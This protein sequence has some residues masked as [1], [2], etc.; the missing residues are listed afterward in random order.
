M[1]Y[2]YKGEYLKDIPKKY[3]LVPNIQ[4][5]IDDLD[6]KRLNKN[7]RTSLDKA[8][9]GILLKEFMDKKSKDYLLAPFIGDAT[10]VGIYKA[11]TKHNEYYFV[12]LSNERELMCEQELYDLSAVKKTVKRLY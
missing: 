2:Y 10:P 1:K 9:L 4:D 3:A 6:K 7:E 8:L 12:K 11:E 5:Y